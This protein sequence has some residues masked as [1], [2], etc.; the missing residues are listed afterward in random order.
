VS[1]L[2][3]GLP[4][5]IAAAIPSE[6]RANE[7][8]Y[9]AA[10]DRLLSDYEGQW[11]AFADGAVVASGT[12]PVEVFR[13]AHESGRHPFVIR[14]GAE[15]EP[16]RMRRCSF[17]Y[18]TA[19]PGE[20]LPLLAAEFRPTSGTTGVVLDRII[21]DTGA[22]A[23]ALPWPDCQ[24]LGLHPSNGIPGLIGGVG[25]SSVATLAFLVWVWLDGQE[26]PCRLQADFSNDERILGRDVLNRV[27]VLFRGP[28]CEVVINP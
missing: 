26:Y 27:D 14:V 16:T 4:P 22:D 11:V 15:A 13:A 24:V 2:A 23:S 19:Y 3:D 18:D 21:P 6:W 28:A 7:A 12:S 25:G 17:P 1:S 9:W 5:E 20:P 8:A 10:R